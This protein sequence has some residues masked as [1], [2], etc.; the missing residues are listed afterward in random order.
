MEQTLVLI[1]PDAVERG[2]VGK[3]ITRFEEKNLQIQAI[4]MLHLTREMAEKLYEEHRG[5]TFY[6]QLISYITLGPLI[7]LILAGP[8]AVNR[9]RLLIGDTAGTTPGTI[10]GDWAGSI[11]YN[12]VH[13]SD[14]LRSATREIKLF[15]PKGDS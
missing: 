14:S 10:R 9:A 12:L 1:K 2:L 15:F 13:G 11:T 5:K 3:I 7:A 8:Q 6:A 4:K